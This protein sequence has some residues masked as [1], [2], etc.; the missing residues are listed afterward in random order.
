M[1]HLRK[2]YKC[3][4]YSGKGHLNDHSSEQWERNQIHHLR[5]FRVHLRHELV[6]DVLGEIEVRGG[7]EQLTQAA[8][9][10]QQTAT[11]LGRF[12]LG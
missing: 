3:K 12:A 7:I 2:G 9:R 6:N 8:H 5:V 4:R 1:R 11:H 10:N